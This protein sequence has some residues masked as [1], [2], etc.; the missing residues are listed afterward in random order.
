VQQNRVIILAVAAVVAVLAI[1]Y[2]GFTLLAKDGS[3]LA[4][5]QSPEAAAKAHAAM[6]EKVMA[7]VG[8]LGDQALGD[9]NA[10]VTVVEYGSLTCSHCSDF[11][12]ESFPELKSK[13]IDTGKVRYILREFSY[14]EYATSAFM[15][16]RCAGNDRYFGFVDV[17]F[18][19]QEQWAYSEDPMAGLLALAKQGG[20]TDATFDACMKN[21]AIFAH[22][23]KV[24]TSGR[25]E[26]GVEST[27][28]FFVNGEKVEGALPFSQF[29]NIVKKHLPPEK[30][31]STSPTPAKAK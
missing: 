30:A 20:F 11:N 13:Y 7:A 21:D 2:A 8:P 27:P 28:T 16:A 3:P 18:R 10:P 15:L 1:G 17:L 19:K 31:Q 23:E 14:D 5:A 9:K 24:T 22:V 25:N 26:F 4:S 29:E 6:A 12:K